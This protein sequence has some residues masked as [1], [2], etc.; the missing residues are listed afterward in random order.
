MTRLQLIA[1]LK[2]N[3]LIT[4]NLLL[5]DQIREDSLPNQLQRRDKKIQYNL[6]QMRS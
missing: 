2:L 5:K 1:V 4:Q 6:N 3:I